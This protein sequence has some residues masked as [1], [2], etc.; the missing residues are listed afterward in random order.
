MGNWLLLEIR[1]YWIR[2][3]SVYL[4]PTSSLCAFSRTPAKNT[5]CDVP[6]RTR[7]CKTDAEVTLVTDFKSVKCK[8]A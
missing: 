8:I 7:Y 3:Q 4:D 2:N 5:A 6:L 1:I